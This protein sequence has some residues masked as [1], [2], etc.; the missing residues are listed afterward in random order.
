MVELI[1]LY[2]IF[3]I[4]TSVFWNIPAIFDFTSFDLLYFAVFGLF[5]LKNFRLIFTSNAFGIYLMDLVTY[6]GFISK[7][8]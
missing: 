3:N 8:A 1:F 6:F 7:E 5:L 2:A 4:L